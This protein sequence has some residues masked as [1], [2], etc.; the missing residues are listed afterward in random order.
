VT[1]VYVGRRLTRGDKSLWMGESLFEGSLE[2]VAMWLGPEFLE[3]PLSR[4]LTK[5]NG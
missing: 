4:G 3:M 5:H 1:T 2:V